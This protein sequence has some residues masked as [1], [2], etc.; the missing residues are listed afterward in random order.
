MAIKTLK[1]V[2][3]PGYDM[4]KEWRHESEA[5][6]ELNVL[7][8]AHIVRG[9]ASFKH[10]RH[11]HLLL[12]W[13][14][15]GSLQSF[16]EE[17]PKPEMNEETIRDLLDQLIGLTDA[18]YAM[19]GTAVAVRSRR[20]SP[21]RHYSRPNSRGSSVSARTTAQDFAV[22]PDRSDSKY[23]ANPQGEQITPADGFP[24]INFPIFSVEPPDTQP[25]PELVIEGEDMGLAAE[26]SDDEDNWRH[27]DIKPGNILRFVEGP[28]SRSIGQL[29]LA[30]LGRAKKN[31]DNT[32][33]RPVVDVD[34]WRSKPYEPPDTFVSQGK[35]STSRLYDVW[36][37]GCVFF[38]SV[39]WMLYGSEYHQSFT[40]TTAKSQTEGSPYWK[41]VGKTARLSDMASVWMTHILKNDPE[42]TQEIGQMG[43]VM[44]DLLR[45]IK[46]KLL[47]V[48]LPQNSKR[49]T[50]G[51]RTN[52]EDL[53][54]DLKELAKRAKENKKYAFRGLD[55]SK[56]VLPPLGALAGLPFLD[57]STPSLLDP[58][59]ALQISPLNAAR[60]QRALT[61]RSQGRYTHAIHDAWSYK[62]DHTFVDTVIG[63]NMEE[64][65]KLC[66]VEQKLCSDCSKIN[67]DVLAS[68]SKRLLV[69][70]RKMR[71]QCALC[72]MVFLAAQKAKLRRD[73]LIG[74]DRVPMGLKLNGQPESVLRV[75]RSFGKSP[76]LSCQSVVVNSGAA[77]DASVLTPNTRV[78]LPRLS[79][80]GGNVHFDMMRAWLLDCDG[81]LNCSKIRSN[82]QKYVPKR[83]LWVGDSVAA[84]SSKV[85]ET[86]HLSD[87]EKMTL[88]YVALSHPWG[89]HSNTNPH[90]CSTPVTIDDYLDE[91]T[92]NELPATFKDAVKVTRELKK[93]YLWIDSICV[94]QGPDGDFKD[95][96]EHM[97]D[98]FS[99][100]YCVVA[101]SSATGMDSGLL[102]PRAARNSVAIPFGESKKINDQLYVSEVLDDFKQDV[103]D[104]PLSQRGWVLQERALA[105]RSIYFSNNQTYWECS[106]GIRCETGGK[107]E[108][109][110]L[111]HRTL[112]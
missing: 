37:L 27:G 19:H 32:H 40:E 106:D 4:E 34:L 26:I 108:K 28:A 38:E 33:Q 25:G 85:I 55:R 111:P 18:L 91:V 56:V 93:T 112:P 36:S 59:T 39:V 49:Y 87:A 79:D 94:I 8:H 48:A 80:C 58:N 105:R 44:G 99:S 16:W 77:M 67:F 102:R 43:T 24:A 42:C 88:V 13:A 60:G 23:L 98:I 35:R 22:P 104:S 54:N 100:A 7:E 64:Y 2:N 95:E 31:K 66:H 73:I 57:S 92:D 101:A 83:L 65:T 69:D 68:L 72:S 50:R 82:A 45:I 62:D 78:G 71:G 11:Y 53:L 103:I 20:P 76:C 47:V 63:Q 46:E 90:F 21:T 29:K 70:L 14:A 30:D 41:R 51:S 12:E 10:G 110:V 1:P 17:C 84:N 97:Q 3:D 107:L 89:V 86:E 96:A 6:K 5:L 75:S 81:H 52:A 61:S 15:G 109:Y 74:L 9:L